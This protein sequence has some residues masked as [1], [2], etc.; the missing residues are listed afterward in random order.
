MVKKTH[1][2]SSKQF[3][4]KLLTFIDT[5]IINAITAKPEDAI[6]ILTGTLTNIKDAILSE[7]IK[8]NFVQDINNKIEK[9]TDNKKNNDQE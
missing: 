2:D 9:T 3:F 7:I 8:D 4:K 6:P 5:S 1:S